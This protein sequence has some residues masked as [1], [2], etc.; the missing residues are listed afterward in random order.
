MLNRNM[1]EWVK[2]IRNSPKRLAIPI[3]THPGIE[4]IRKRT[5]DAVKSHEVQYSAI[6][7]IQKRFAPDAATMMMD[8]TLEAEAFGSDVDFHENE[9]PSL[10]GKLLEDSAAIEKLV[11]P[12][13]N[14]AR[15]RQQLSSLQNVTK[16]IT[17]KP[18][19]AVCIGPFSLAGRL[20]GL[21]EIMT[22]I[23]IEPEAISVL[24]RKCSLFL[25]QYI[26]ETKKVGAD[27]IIMAEPAA[28]LLSADLCDDFSS[29]YIREIVSQ[30]QDGSFL[31][32]LHNCGNTGHVTRSMIS[33]G[34]GGLHFGNK[35][36]LL[37]VLSIVPSNVLVMGN[38]D[39]V[40]VFKSSTPDRVHE[41]TAQ[42]LSATISKGNFIISS[43]CDLPPGTP[44][45]N[46]AAFFKAVREFN[47]KHERRVIDAFRY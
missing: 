8:L 42:L 16:T 12:S 18:V 10:S 9:I 7:A 15:I 23:L 11:V 6:I 4:I 20:F 33:T 43:G 1:E 21:S 2:S 27:G 22:S 41:S 34:A 46:V 24:V 36:D 38:L 32:I 26:L 14:M 39:P 28:G 31:F 45:E 37:D 30:V 19:F 5:I 35:V 3:M 29:H 25:A 17:D 13:L 47:A 44:A 40:G